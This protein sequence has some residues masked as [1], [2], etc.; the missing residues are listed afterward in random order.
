MF[1]VRYEL[2]IFTLSATEVLTQ[3]ILARIT[4]VFTVPLTNPSGSLS[5][6]PIS[7]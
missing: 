6:L 4:I 2:F 7:R 3:A 5:L 1:L